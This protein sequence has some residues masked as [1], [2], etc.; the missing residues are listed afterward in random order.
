MAKN[1][2]S[3]TILQYLQAQEGARKYY[4]CRLPSFLPFSPICLNCKREEKEPLIQATL[5]FPHFHH[6]NLHRLKNILHL[7]VLVVP[8]IL[9]RKTYQCL[10]GKE[11]L[12]LVA[13]RKRKYFTY[14]IWW[15]LLAAQQLNGRLVVHLQFPNIEKRPPLP[16]KSVSWCHFLCFYEYIKSVGIVILEPLAK[17]IVARFQKRKVFTLKIFFFYQ[18]KIQ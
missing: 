1:M 12:T 18:T 15:H 4:H 5:E 8:L 7:T 2:T 14:L 3:F 6:A 11:K 17:N 16:K 10:F 13:P 9:R